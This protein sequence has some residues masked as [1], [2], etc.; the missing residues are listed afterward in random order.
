MEHNWQIQV[1]RVSWVGQSTRGWQALGEGGVMKSWDE[2]KLKR[3][4]DVT[5][6]GPTNEQQDIANQPMDAGRLSWAIS[7][8]YELSKGIYIK[9]MDTSTK[10]MQVQKVF[11]SSIEWF[12]ILVSQRSSQRA[13][14]P[15]IQVPKWPANRYKARKLKSCIF[16]RK[17]KNCPFL[18]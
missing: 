14:N 2:K 17:Q 3:E 8:F 9:Y 18:A 1:K 7:E 15:M 12:K 10:C 11:P 6:M 5:I 4:K 13:L 16:P